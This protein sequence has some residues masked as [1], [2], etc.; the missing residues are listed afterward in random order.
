MAV[1]KI[2]FA[3]TDLTGPIEFAWHSVLQYN[4]KLRPRVKLIIKAFRSFFFYLGIV[5]DNTEFIKL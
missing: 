4:M 1:G 2:C 3:Q 5:L